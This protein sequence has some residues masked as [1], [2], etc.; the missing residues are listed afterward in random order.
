MTNAPFYVHAS[1]IKLQDLFIAFI[2]SYKYNIIIPL[3][4]NIR[5]S[6]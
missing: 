6:R 5:Q 1:F 3:K 2:C 4:D